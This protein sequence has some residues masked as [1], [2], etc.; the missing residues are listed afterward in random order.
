MP[1]HIE[2]HYRYLVVVLKD[3]EKLISES[4]T[5]YYLEAFNDGDYLAN[6]YAINMLLVLSKFNEEQYYE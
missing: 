2:D 5:K 1:L 6:S 4:L 3:L